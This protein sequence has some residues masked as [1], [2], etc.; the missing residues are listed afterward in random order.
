MSLAKSI[1]EKILTAIS[2]IKNNPIL[3]ALAQ[4]A[5]EEIPVI[6]G[7]LV[8]LYENAAGDEE[9]K[10]EQILQILN[11]LSKLNEESLE[12]IIEGLNK[13]RDEI[14]KNRCYLAQLLV[15]TDQII[16]RL[17]KQE[18]NS[19]EIKIG[20]TEIHIDLTKLRL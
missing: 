2:T 20:Q 19:H 17:E 14:I 15:D 8:K 16:T 3:D 18:L 4:S 13:N 11:N 12:K 9:D 10:T 7:L 6:G 5:L 1:K